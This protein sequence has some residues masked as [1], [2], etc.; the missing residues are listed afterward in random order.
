MPEDHQE[1][2][3]GR[4]RDAERGTSSW[5]LKR[6]NGLGG[7]A[8]SESGSQ[9]PNEEGSDSETPSESS[10]EDTQEVSTHQSDGP[11]QLLQALTS[12]WK[13]HT[14]KMVVQI[15]RSGIDI[16]ERLKEPWDPGFGNF[17]Q[18]IG[19]QPLHFAVRLGLLKACTA[20]ID[21]KA[22][23]DAQTNTGV[24]ALMVAV[25]F[26]RLDV[27]RLLVN[28]KA[29]VLCQDQ[30]G[31]S[32]TDMAILEGSPQMVQML[33][34][35]EQQEDEEME[36]EVMQTA[37]DAGADISLLPPVDKTLALDE[38]LILQQIIQI[39]RAHV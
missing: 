32:V 1:K 11:G 19:A 38:Q 30:N 25:M 14:E 31:L 22:E 12:K 36:N 13:G 6:R 5:T 17:K 24:S 33:L 9:L 27:A 2:G 8:R 3:D 28:A 16:N 23:V 34:E 15:I 37:I 29:S 21:C 4:A 10:E 26:S 7:P 18:T 35:R 39:G 20:L